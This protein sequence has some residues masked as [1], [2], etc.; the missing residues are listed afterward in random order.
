MEILS[1]LLFHLFS[2][3]KTNLLQLQHLTQQRF[4]FQILPKIIK[5]H[6]VS[7]TIYSHLG[8]D[9]SLECQCPSDLC[10]PIGRVHF[11]THL[12]RLW[13]NHHSSTTSISLRWPL[14]PHKT[15]R[16]HWRGT[17]HGLSLLR[18]KGLGAQ[19]RSACQDWQWCG[20]GLH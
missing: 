18:R 9:G 1:M 5:Q 4:Q 11:S 19:R 2:L 17:C 15:Q 7:C 8:I 20:S 13:S 14:P 16:L 12:T 10:M 6:E 3:L